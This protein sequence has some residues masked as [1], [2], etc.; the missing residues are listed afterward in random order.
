MNE[1]IKQK[2][3]GEFIAKISVFVWL[4]EF[5]IQRFVNKD[6]SGISILAGYCVTSFAVDF[7]SF[8]N[9]NIKSNIKKLRKILIFHLTFR[10]AI[11]L[12]FSFI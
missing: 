11:R 4:I 6:K 8:W 7:G 12:K 10:I 1:Y 9:N 5:G 3:E 2:L